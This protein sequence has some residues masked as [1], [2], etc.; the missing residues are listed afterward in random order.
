VESNFYLLP[1]IPASRLHCFHDSQELLEFFLK[2]ILRM[3]ETMMSKPLSFIDESLRQLC[4][5]CAF[6]GQSITFQEVY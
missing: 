5:G 1:E 2:E 3:V 6:S 4:S